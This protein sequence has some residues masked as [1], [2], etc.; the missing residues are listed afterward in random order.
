LLLARAGYANRWV[1][2]YSMRL[3][4]KLTPTLIIFLA[5][6]I[7]LPTSVKAESTTSY[8]I[9]N[10]SIPE[11]FRDVYA[12]LEFIKYPKE[13]DDVFNAQEA[14]YWDISRFM[15]FI[16]KNGVLFSDV[17][18]R[19]SGLKS[20]AQIRNAI[21]NR[22]GRIFTAFAHLAHIYSVPYKQYSELGFEKKDKDFIVHL[23]DWYQLTFKLEGKRLRMTKCNY[24]TLESD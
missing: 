7:C 19:L 11:N 15:S 2:S 17:N 21:S 9:S 16:S 6:G 13:P 14:P 20:P 23:S 12:F 8:K 1:E 18:G 4:T 22:K 3:V 10:R 5:V 24:L